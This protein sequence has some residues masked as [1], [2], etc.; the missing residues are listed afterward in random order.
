M[1]L[2]AKAKNVAEIEAIYYNKPKNDF[3]IPLKEARL[4]V[5]EA[6]KEVLQIDKDNVLWWKTKYEHEIAKVIAY[7]NWLAQQ[8][9]KY[10]IYLKITDAKFTFN[11]VFFDSDEVE[12]TDGRIE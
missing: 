1:S 9:E 11:Q 2:E 4:A 6:R 8:S 5:L 10:S 7:R 12:G 3:W